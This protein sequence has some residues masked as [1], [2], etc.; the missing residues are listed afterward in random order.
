MKLDIFE[1]LKEESL[2]FRITSYLDQQKIEGK[3]PNSLKLC[4]H[5]KIVKKHIKLPFD[6]KVGR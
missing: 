1:I 4:F 2:K 5:E 3:T 6:L